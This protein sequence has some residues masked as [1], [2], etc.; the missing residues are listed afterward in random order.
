MEESC[1]NKI[2]KKKKKKDFWDLFWGKRKVAQY[3]CRT[4]FFLL[5]LIFIIIYYYYLIIL[6]FTLSQLASTNFIPKYL[7]T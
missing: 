6:S 1:K 7:S 5:F 3:G 4:G 2:W